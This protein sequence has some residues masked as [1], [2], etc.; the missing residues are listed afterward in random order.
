MKKQKA[1]HRLQKLPNLLLKWNGSTADPVWGRIVD[2]ITL[3]SGLLEDMDDGNQ[4][5]QG[6]LGI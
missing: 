1:L 6:G 3:I 2:E 5:N 4:G